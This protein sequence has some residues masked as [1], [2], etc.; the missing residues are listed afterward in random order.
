MQP[1]TTES[2]ESIVIGRSDRYLVQMAIEELPLKFREVVLLCD[3]EELS[4][5]EMAEILGTPI[6][7]IMSRLARARSALRSILM[8]KL[9]KE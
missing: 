3:L 4:Y 7:T 1:V 5:K 2:P 8:K 9:Q 6:G